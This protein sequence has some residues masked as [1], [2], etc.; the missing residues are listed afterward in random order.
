MLDDRLDDL[1]TRLEQRRAELQQEQQCTISNINIW[2][3]PGSATEQETSV[4][5]KMV[6]DPEIETMAV[7]A[8]IAYEPAGLAGAECGAGEPR[9]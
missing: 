6:S 9:F 4:G 5:R 1:N 8:V 3:V 2:A 7:Q